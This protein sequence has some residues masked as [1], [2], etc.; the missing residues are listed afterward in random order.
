MINLTLGTCI[1]QVCRPEGLTK[2]NL[3]T[4]L[5]VLFKFDSGSACA[6]QSLT[7]AARQA[8]L[9]LMDR[10]TQLMLAASGPLTLTDDLLT[11]DLNRWALRLQLRS[12]LFQMFCHVMLFEC[13]PAAVSD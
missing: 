10:E 1:C 4:S 2:A 13:T 12:S 6:P 11:D 5:R 7:S 9:M 8:K 3:R